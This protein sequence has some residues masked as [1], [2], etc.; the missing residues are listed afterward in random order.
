MKKKVVAVG[1][2]IMGDDGIAIKVIKELKEILEENNYEVI[3]GETDVEYCLSK[4]EKNDDLIIV[5]SCYL[6]T[7]PGEVTL[8]PFESIDD[9]FNNS[10][11]QHD[12]SL[13]KAL[14]GK[15]GFIRGYLLGIEISIIEFNLEL[16]EELKKRFPLICK[17]VKNILLYG[18]GGE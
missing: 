10:F 5:D 12:R 6:G 7:E 3:I 9:Y 1:N 13:L 2:I 11:S 18:I 15:D 17:K 14:K 16:S 4:I 8:I